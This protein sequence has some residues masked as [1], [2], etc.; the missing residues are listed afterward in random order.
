MTDTRERYHRIIREHLCV[1]P[2]QITDEAR[3]VEDL[4]ADSLD[5]IELGLA[6]EDAFEIVVTDEDMESFVT[7]KDGLDLVERLLAAKVVA[8][9]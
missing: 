5:P 7:V 6:F 2:E 8:R 3:L 9:G 1:A 4:G